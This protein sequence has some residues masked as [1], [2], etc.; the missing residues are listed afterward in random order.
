MKY[1]EDRNRETEGG[2]KE[3]KQNKCILL[4]QNNFDQIIFLFAD[5]VNLTA[6]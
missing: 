2:S 4:F 3:K 6:M 1:L 5:P